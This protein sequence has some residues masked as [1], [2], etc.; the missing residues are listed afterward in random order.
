MTELGP[1]GDRG[2][3]AQASWDGR[4]RLDPEEGGRT[5][6]GIASR[7]TE[8]SRGALRPR[9]GGRSCCVQLAQ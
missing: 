8:R 6:S 4:A 7:V 9:V 3:S 2:C 5:L 1:L